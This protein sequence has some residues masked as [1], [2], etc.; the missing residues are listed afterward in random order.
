VAAPG[1]S[2]AVAGKAKRRAVKEPRLTDRRRE[3][4]Q[5]YTLL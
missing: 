1:I 5:D 3:R 2:G 4:L